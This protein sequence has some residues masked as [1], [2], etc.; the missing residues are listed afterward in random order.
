MYKIYLLRVAFLPT[1]KC[2]VNFLFIFFSFL[3]ISFLF[4]PFFFFPAEP[5][6]LRENSSSRAV[7]CLSWLQVFSTSSVL[8]F[9]VLLVG[10]ADDSTAKSVRLFVSSLTAVVKAFSSSAVTSPLQNSV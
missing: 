10:M 7:S 9:Q 3:S 4:F 1:V 8:E 2:I 5:Q 6:A